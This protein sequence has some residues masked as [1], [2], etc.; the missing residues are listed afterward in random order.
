MWLSSVFI[1]KADDLVGVQTDLRL[2]A[3]VEDR[4]KG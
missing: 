1:A 3:I 4:R 2:I